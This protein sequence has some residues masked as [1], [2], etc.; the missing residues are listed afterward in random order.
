MEQSNELIKLNCVEENMKISLVSSPRNRSPMRSP[1][2]SPRNRS[3]VNRVPRNRSQEISPEISPLGSPRGS[4]RNRSP[5]NRVPRNRS[6]EISPIGSPRN[7]SPVN[8]S[9]RYLSRNISPEIS[10]LMSPIGSSRGSPRGSPRNRS[11]VLTPSTSPWC[12]PRNRSPMRSPKGSPRNRSPMRSP[13]GSPRVRSL[14]YLMNSHSG[15]SSDSSDIY[16]NISP[17]GS[18]RSGSP[19]RILRSCSSD[20]F[21]MTS[22]SMSPRSRSTSPTNKYSDKVNCSATPTAGFSLNKS[23]DKLIE[24]T[25]EKI[26]KNASKSKEESY[27]DEDNDLSEENDSS[28]ESDSGEEINKLKETRTRY[29]KVIHPSI[30]EGQA[31]GRFTGKTARRAASKAF[32]SI[33]RNIKGD[34]STNPITFDIKECSRGSSKKVYKYEGKRVRLNEPMEI[35]VEVD[36]AQKTLTYHFNNTIKKVSHQINDVNVNDTPLQIENKTNALKCE[37]QPLNKMNDPIIVNGS[38]SNFIQIINNNSEEKLDQVDE[39]SDQ[40]DENSNQI[41]E[42]MDN[43]MFDKISERHYFHFLSL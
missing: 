16:P 41:N 14:N 21:N 26:S 29:F 28:E 17:I 24:K 5:V 42:K 4:P 15:S 31:T 35:K 25:F 33:V 39:N 40:V 3:P 6:Q 38:T 34:D 37:T 10:P 2:C 19:S 32:T 8:R 20:L 11:P 9:F 30:N 13:K 7:R 23:T 43:N 1:E 18:P 12:S 22:T 36:G 27:S